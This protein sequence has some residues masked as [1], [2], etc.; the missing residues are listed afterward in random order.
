M[1]AQDEERSG[2]VHEKLAAVHKPAP[3]KNQNKWQPTGSNQHLQ[4]RIV[5]IRSLMA[6]A[7]LH[8]AMR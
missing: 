8:N 2:G 1:I 6:G 3:S 7:P 4:I 5:A